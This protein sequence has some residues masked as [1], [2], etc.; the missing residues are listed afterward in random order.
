M[1][2]KKDLEI[3]LKLFEIDP[4]DTDF[5]R[6]YLAA[7]EWA[8]TTIKSNMAENGDKQLPPN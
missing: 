6:G 3:A 8:D 2:F 7:L 1:E 4:P 5:Q